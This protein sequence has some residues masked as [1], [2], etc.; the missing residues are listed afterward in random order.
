MNERLHGEDKSQQVETQ[1]L[2]K[3]WPGVWLIIST[4]SIEILER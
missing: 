3:V 1:K 2:P 4:I